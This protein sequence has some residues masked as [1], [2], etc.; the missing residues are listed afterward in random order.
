[1]VLKRQIQWGL[2]GLLFGLVCV[3][4]GIGLGLLARSLRADSYTQE[5]E[6][7]LGLSP[8]ERREL[9]RNYERFLSLSA[10]EQQQARD[11]HAELTAAPDVEQLTTV[12]E[13]YVEW[14]KTLSPTQRSQLTSLIGEEEERLALVDEYQRDQLRKAPLTTEDIQQVVA[15]LD[16]IVR[17]Y[18]ESEGQTT[19]ED[20]ADSDDRKRRLLWFAS[21]RLQNRGGGGR[22]LVLSQADIQ[23]LIEKLSPQARQ[24][25][26]DAKTL[27]E[28]RQEVLGWVYLAMRRLHGGDRWQ[29]EEVSERELVQFYD[30]KLDDPK[31][32]ELLSLPPAERIE[33]LRMFYFRDKY[34]DRPF[35][36]P[37][38]GRPP[39]M[40]S[41]GPRFDGPRL[42]G[43]RF[44]GS[45]FD[46]DRPPPPMGDPRNRRPLEE[47]PSGEDS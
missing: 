47:N 1:M 3:G 2:L 22:A 33:R 7:L 30:K 13:N 31:R 16:V 10:A 8:A 24:R 11:F 5:R 43:P 39:G 36:P 19:L 20:S 14:V 38:F 25:L 28:K 23:Q 29:P 21:Q 18:L 45:R 12:L 6:E 27:P 4:S 17:K 34:P 9:L 32:E 44:D 35:G 15:W 37:G 26:A 40:R 41:D 46:G 42:E